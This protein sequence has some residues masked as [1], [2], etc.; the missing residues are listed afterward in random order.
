VGAERLRRRGGDQPLR[1]RSATEEERSATEEERGLS[2]RT[3]ESQAT[4]H[5]ATL[6]DDEQEL[7][8]GNE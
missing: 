4:E 3:V 5:R 7:L 6:N 2:H 1:R 8:F